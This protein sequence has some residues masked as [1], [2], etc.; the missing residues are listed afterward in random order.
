MGRQVLFRWW[1][2]SIEGPASSEN[3]VKQSLAEARLE[4]RN[5]TGFS[6]FRAPVSRALASLP[7]SKITRKSF[8][9]IS[10]NLRNAPFSG[11][12]GRQTFFVSV[13][14]WRTF[15]GIWMPNRGELDEILKKAG[16]V[17][18]DRDIRLLNRADIA[19][20]LASKNSGRIIIKKLM[21]SIIWQVYRGIQ[22]G[23]YPP[24]IGN[25]RTFWYLYTKPVLAKIHDDD[26][27]KSD[28]YEMML[29]AFHELIMVRGLFTYA[30]FDFT[31]EGWEQRRIGKTQ[32]E[33][34]IFSEKTGWIRL[35]R[36][37]HER[38]DCSV[39]ALGGFP[40]ALTSEYTATH[41]KKVVGEKTVRL[42]GIV[43]YDPSGY[44]IASSFCDQLRAVG[45][46]VSEPELLI[47]PD[48]YEADELE[49]FAYPISRRQKTKLRNWMKLTN[50]VG[51]KEFGLE[52][53]SLPIDRIEGVLEEMLGSG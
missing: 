16:I 21:K 47:H 43:D 52:S 25:I 23:S 48:R 50:G 37:W 38:W 5:Q 24:L 13:H 3:A 28:P 14:G 34:L 26:R 45:L 33:V 6:H 27:L 17:E 42:V 40:S 32:P 35:L 39:L 41:L 4:V 8:P 11:R 12:L 20:K 7:P 36:R 1:T 2:K 30:S 18:F 49:M 51:G 29:R 19:E 22:E 10:R 15:G 53:E 31:D 9:M 46:K 44:M